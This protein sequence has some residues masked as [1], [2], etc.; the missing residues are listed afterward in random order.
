MKSILVT[1]IISLSLAGFSQGSSMYRTIYNP[2]EPFGG[3]KGFKDL[4]KQCM[5]Y[6]KE[7]I[8]NNIEGEVFIT[9][10][11]NSKGVVIAKSVSQEA[12]ESIAKEAE[13]IFDQIIWVADPY[14]KDD[15]LGL[16]KLSIRFK[17]KRYNKL[18]KKRGYDELP[19]IEN[20]YD[21]ELATYDINSVDEKP[22]YSNIKNFRSFLQD[23][24]KYPDVAVQQS[25]SGRVTVRFIIEPYGMASNIQVID[26]VGGGCNG[27][28]IRLVKL[29]RW[30]PA[31]IDGK[32]VRCISEYQLNFVNPGGSVR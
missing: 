22:S 7:A 14:R 25:L 24:F 4:V 12:G 18:V 10:R 23:N 3:E 31:T 26:P 8:E 11:V 1:I 21:V 6:P 16:E 17:I 5:V 32:A 9:F 28:T 20:I 2:A 27:E 19:L 29:M 30:K 13:R 15:E